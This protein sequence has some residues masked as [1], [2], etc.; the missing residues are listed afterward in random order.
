MVNIGIGVLAFTGKTM[1]FCPYMLPIPG[2]QRIGLAGTESFSLR[3]A[4]IKQYHVIGIIWVFIR[5]QE[6]ASQT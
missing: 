6:S 4:S 1:A 2:I 5:S 3:T